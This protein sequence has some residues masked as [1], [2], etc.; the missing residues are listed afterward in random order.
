MSVNR[1]RANLS[2][3]MG[4]WRWIAGGVLC[5][6]MYGNWRWRL[7]LRQL[8]WSRYLH[9]SWCWNGRGGGVLFDDRGEGVC[10]DETH[11]EERLENGVGE[12]RCLAE[13]LDCFGSI[14]GYELFHL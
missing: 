10:G 8:L 3:Q 6:S 11:E 2:A 1:R 4:R 9:S 12:L 13:E 14:G 5:L 7:I